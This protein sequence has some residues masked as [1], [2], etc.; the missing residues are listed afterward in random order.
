M[1][2]LLALA[3]LIGQ[4]Q[5]PAAPVVSPQAPSP[6]AVFAGRPVVRAEVSIEGRVTDSPMLEELIETRPG[7]TL[8]M[9]S[10]RATI[11]HLF[12]LG[13]FQ[14]IS[15][16]ARAVEGGVALTYAL[17]P[18]HSVQRIEFRGNLG[19]PESALRRAVTDRFG[20]APPASRA[21]SVAEMLQSYYFDRGYLGAAIR[22]VVEVV[23]EPDGTILTFEIE[24]GARASIR[25]VTLAGD[26]GE[27]RE[28]FLRTI[29]ANPGRPYER[30]DVQERLADYLERLRHDGRYE[31]HGS[32]RLVSQSDD[33]RSVDLAV[34]IERGPE[35][36]V[37]FEG[38]PL[39]KDRI[40]DLVPVRREGSV[41]ADILED[42]ERRI[43]AYLNQ[44]GYWKASATAVRRELDGRVEIVFTVRKGL[45]YRVDGGALVSGNVSVPMEEIRPLL[46]RL[47]PGTLFIAANLDAASAAI[48][49]L[50]LRRGFAQVK[51]DSAANERNPSPSGEGRIQPSIVIVEGP[52]T[53]VGQVTFAGNKAISSA[54]LSARISTAAGQPYYEPQ[55]IQDRENILGEYLNRGFSEASVNVVPSMADASRV[56]VR[57]DITEGI[58][59]IVD[60]VMIVGNAKT[61]VRV[62][63]REIQLRPGEPLALE[64]LFETR[65]RLGGLGLFRRI[66]ITEIQHGDSNLHDILITVEEAPSTNI[67]Y[68][69]GLE[70]SERLATSAE[71]VAEERFELAPRGF[72]E[73]GRRNIG[74]KNRSVNIYT[75]VSLRSDNNGPSGEDQ[76]FGF[77]EYRVVGTYR[78]P[79]TFGWN[80]DVTMTAAVERGVR[81][82]FKFAREGINAEILRSLTPRIRTSARYTFGTTKT[83]DKALTEQEEAAIDRIFPQVRLSALSGTIARDTRDDV[84]DPS[85]GFFLTAEGS[86]A[87]RAMGGQV[88]F[89]KS[90]F[91]G[92]AYRRL[93]I[94]RRTI[95]AGRVALGLADGFPRE[96]DVLDAGGNPTTQIVEDL[97]ASE[98]FFA[99]G[100]T[101]MRGFALDSVGTER[102]ITEK[103]F[104]RG[105]N[106][107]V[108][109]NGE[110]RLPVWKDLGAAVFV[111]AGNVFE[112]ATQ[113]DFGELRAAVGFGL[114]YRSPVGPLRFDLGFKV[115][116]RRLESSRAFHLSFGQ[117]F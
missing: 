31:A 68:G 24:A 99:G 36:I 28:R 38:D 62:I 104:P 51:V 117:A 6:A 4:A 97:P 85:R 107:V 111:D 21:A 5:A 64:A 2:I 34:T 102:T 58:Q 115:N 113:I 63:E 39:P 74:G 10:V 46:E 95:F 75:R 84:L 65:R 8:S 88:G 94:G 61:D 112:R 37:R 106:G 19:L 69:G 17:V 27:P 105:G 96:V 42:S 44:Q 79:R 53:R 73:I 47:E 48:R 81:S 87:A 23:H 25:D 26:P 82:T 50:Y 29:H 14:E 56:D 41:D 30:V 52:L 100:D 116:R 11:A 98:R 66:R 60:H 9:V 13:R 49:G 15:V 86:V 20:S 32:H 83:F 43:V 103:G 55:V 18:V 78:E 76:T 90:I 45:Q 108:L 80:A 1:G 57:F 22:P 16:D 59:S 35:V 92:H 109:L 91:Q 70:L 40:E 114:R 12:S 7:S 3:L 72:F 54:D 67:G 110:L 89:L 101:T 71:G 93:P 33:G 77:P